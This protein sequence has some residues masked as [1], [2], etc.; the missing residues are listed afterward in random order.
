MNQLFN[1]T[2][3]SPYCY[4]LWVIIASITI[5]IYISFVEA[6]EK[7][8]KYFCPIFCGCGLSDPKGEENKKIPADRLT[9][10]FLG[11]LECSAYPLLMKVELPEYIGAWLVFK[12]V[13]RWLYKKQDRGLFNRYL[14]AN[15][16]GLFFSYLL[17]RFLLT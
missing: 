11:I 7:G 3:P 2:I 1:L 15:G 13:N 16:L 6:W 14:V 8:W 17:A 9:G 10:L 4:F 5:R 12:T